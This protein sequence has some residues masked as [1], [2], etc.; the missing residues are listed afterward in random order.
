MKNVDRS[1]RV[2]T[3]FKTVKA[4]PPIISLKVIDNFKLKI[5]FE[6]ML[7]RIVDLKKFPLLGQAKKL[8][9][10]E[11]FLKSFK[12]IDGIPEWNEQCL[13]GPEDLLKHSKKLA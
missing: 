3:S 10:D 11:K 4:A 7:P 1:K 5:E 2:T 13:L 9:I 6:G 12:L 8:I